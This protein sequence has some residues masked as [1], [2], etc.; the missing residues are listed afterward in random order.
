LLRRKLA[1]T[2]LSLANSA[3]E[4]RTVT[5][6][7]SGSVLQIAANAIPGKLTTASGL[8][9]RRAGARRYRLSDLGYWEAESGCRTA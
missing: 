5:V 3:L 2:A 4:S 6:G 7:I 1:A 8:R 9:D